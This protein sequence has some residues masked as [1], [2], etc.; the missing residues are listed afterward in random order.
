MKKNHLFEG[1]ILKS[2]IVISTPII[3][4]NLLQTVYQLIDTFWVG[5]LGEEAVAAVS[6]GAPVLFLLLSLGMGF[7]M[8]GTIFVS[9]YNGRKDTKS[10]ALISGQT[11]MLTLLLA[12]V[13]S[14]I[15][16][17]GSEFILS[18]LTSDPAVL[19]PAVDYLKISF[20]GLPG[21]MLFMV[22]QSLLRGVGE[23]KLPM[24]LVM[25]TVILNIFLDPLFLFG[26][27]WLGVPAMGVKGVAWATLIT[28]YLSAIIGI[29]IL[30]TKKSEVSLRPHLSDLRLRVEWVKKIFR[31]GWPSS[32][33]HSTRSIG[34]FIMTFLVAMFGTTAV[35]A[36]GIG[37]RLLMFVIIPAVGFSIATGTLVGNNIGAKNFQ[38]A[39]DISYMGIKV[40]F[41]A[42]MG[43]GI[44]LFFFAKQISG[45]FVPGE[46][47]VIEMS[48]R[49]IKI[50]AL[51]FGFIG[52]QMGIMG[53]L[54]ASGMTRLSLL[55]AVFQ[56]AVLL[57]ATTLLSFVFDMGVDGVWW[58]Y[59]ISNF[60][61]L[62]LAFFFY[63]TKDWNRSL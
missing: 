20:L 51:S 60:V 55:V 52:A 41:W 23:V 17:E 47:A 22:F 48:A 53:T 21:V 11:F 40:G 2:L 56:T 54:K 14:I 33:E 49:F 24:Y 10:T 8:S 6:L 30:Y 15:G 4:G 25:G 38:R 9:Q 31:L 13:V 43:I 37:G 58:A 42:L 35:A 61:V 3:L 16:W 32:I 34:M 45:F 27:E 1:P 50:M 19:A 62:G 7:T 39:K 59:P 5:R 36:Y 57:L 26:N 29:I 46:T 44:L 63:Y 18:K 12:F 28:E